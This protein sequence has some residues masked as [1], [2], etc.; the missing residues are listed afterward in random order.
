MSL[1]TIIDFLNPINLSMIND[2]EAFKNTQLGKHVV[3]Y[4]NDFPDITNADIVL[5]GCDEFRGAGILKT[6]ES[7]VNKVRHAFYNLYHW[8]SAVSIAD[9]GNVKIGANLQDTYAA[10]KAIVSELIALQKRVV[11]IGG[12][13]DIMLAQY[14]AYAGAQKL[15]EAVSIDAKIDLDMDSALPTDKFLMEVLTG[16]PNFIKHYSHIGF[17][18]YLVHPQMLETIDKL[19]FDCYRVGKV[20]EALEEMEPTIRNADIFSFD[21]TAI[22]HAHAP[23]N[24]LTPNGFNGEE[25]C[26]LMQYAGMSLKPCSVGIYGYLHIQ[27]T[28]SLTAKQIAHMLWYLMDGV[29]K[30]K[31]ESILAE[32]ENFNEVHLAFA[33]I[34]TTFLQSKKTGRWWMQLHDGKFIPCS[35]TDYIVASQNEIPERWMRA[36][37]RS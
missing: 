5:I 21:I 7:S 2:D 32:K 17:Q 8:H 23:A 33:E 29:Y 15:S 25:A 1:H 9:I 34:E 18:S 11:V 27:D 37:E 16:E 12:S 30:G 14:S 4:E 24:H 10:V 31:Q 26:I 36:V 20:K 35:K 28:S 13:H 22:Q 6:T 3:V 19:G